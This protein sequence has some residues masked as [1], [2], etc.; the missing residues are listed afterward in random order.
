VQVGGVHLSDVHVRKMHTSEV[1]AS[2]GPPAQDKKPPQVVFDIPPLSERIQIDG[3]KNPEMIPQWDAWQAAFQI[4]EKVGDLPTDLLKQVS[5]EEAASI[6][7]AARENAQNLRE[8]EQRAL[9]LVPT[10]KTEEARL[11]NERTQALNLDCRWQTL[12]LRDRVLA[13]LSPVGQVALTRYVEFTKAGIRVYVPK[14]EL[15]FYRLPQ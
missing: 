13:D 8:C 14:N 12:R 7:D 2:A 3:S 11:I 5:R 1:R 9:K 4:M 15:S 10:L 6:L